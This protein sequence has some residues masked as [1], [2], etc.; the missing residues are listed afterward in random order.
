MPE[1]WRVSTGQ[2]CQRYIIQLQISHF[3]YRD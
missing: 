1:E 2:E 3:D